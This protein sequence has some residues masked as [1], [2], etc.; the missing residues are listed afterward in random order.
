MNGAH[1]K[2]VFLHFSYY[3]SKIGYRKAIA[4]FQVIGYEAEGLT[5]KQKL[6]QN[7]IIVN[8]NLVR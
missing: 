4:I 6:L 5:V 1:L 8:N 7:L 2:A 3:T